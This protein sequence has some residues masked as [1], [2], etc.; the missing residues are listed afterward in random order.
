M[1]SPF[2]ITDVNNDWAVVWPSFD[3]KFT[4][5]M[6]FNILDLIFKEIK[7]YE[8]GLGM[9]DTDDDGKLDYTIMWIKQ[10]VWF[11]DLTDE[12]TRYMYKYYHIGGAVFHERKEAE[13]FKDILE[14]RY[15]WQLLKE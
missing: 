4:D 8:V 15:A 9:A 10:D 2:E 1:N 11:N 13:Q 5:K 3:T 6:K 7:C 12:Y 14:K